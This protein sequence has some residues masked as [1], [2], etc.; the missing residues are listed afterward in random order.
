M[1]FAEDLAPLFTD[2]AEAVSV[3]GVAVRGI[4]DMAADLQLGDMLTQA[5]AL[6]VPASVAAA[7][8]QACTIRATAYVIRQVLDMPPDGALRQLVLT[9]AA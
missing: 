6:T 5:P 2:F 3:N 9:R 1:D 7:E 8:G 4:F